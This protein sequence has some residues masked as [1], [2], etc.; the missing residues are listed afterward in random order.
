[1]VFQSRGRWLAA[2]GAV[3]YFLVAALVGAPGALAGQQVSPS[4]GRP[5]VGGTEAH[6]D[7]Y[8]FMAAL[9]HKGESASVTERHFCG[10]T[11]VHP[12]LVMT[13]AHCAERVS[14]SDMEIVVGRTNLNDVSQG[15]VYRVGKGE[16]FSI[17][18]GRRTGTMTRR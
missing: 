2:A 6:T 5:I 12:L 14:Q 1:M 16:F 3:T 11:L 13:A 9:L 10:G 8:P 7:A 15:A 4:Q 17:R 18:A